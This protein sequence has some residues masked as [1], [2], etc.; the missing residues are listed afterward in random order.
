MERDVLHSENGSQIKRSGH[1]VVES[2]NCFRPYITTWKSEL[3]HMAGI[4]AQKGRIETGGDLFGL[5]SHGDKPVI[6]FSTPPGPNAIQESAHFRQDPDFLRQ[7]SHLL[8]D[9]YGIQ[10]LGNYHSHHWLNIQGLS[11]GDIASVHSI[12][13]RNRY[14]RLSQIVITFQNR[15]HAHPGHENQQDNKEIASKDFIKN[16]T[17]SISHLTSNSH[18]EFL[19]IHSYLYSD[20]K[21]GY[22]VEC[23]IRVL[24]GL[25]PLRETLQRNCKITQLIRHH[26]FPI[27]R[28]LYH[29]FHPATETPRNILEL[30]HWLNS[31]SFS[32]PQEI[33]KETTFQFRE[34]LILVSLP[35]T[36]REGILLIALENQPP[37]KMKSVVFFRERPS[38]VS[39][40]LTRYMQKVP[41]LS[42]LSD[43]YRTAFSVM[44]QNNLINRNEC[45]T[46]EGSVCQCRNNMIHQK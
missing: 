39:I 28:I 21:C 36:A 41:S 34:G 16:K 1:C 46:E 11:M 7:V 14:T 32:L 43:I 29:A 42:Q 22:P 13:K 9:E 12:A 19:K 38:K 45:S 27:E 37:H 30:N 40:D 2:A 44:D 31:Q 6:M 3:E 17:T 23:A 8:G 18:I 33:L 10:Y 25:S 20:A 26:V 4:A 5:M 15:N 24:P 35:M